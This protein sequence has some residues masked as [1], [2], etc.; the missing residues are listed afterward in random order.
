MSD[1]TTISHAVAVA[2]A[3][4]HTSQLWPTIGRAGSALAAIGGGIGSILAWYNRR[5]QKELRVLVNGNLGAALSGIERA[6]VELA[7]ATAERDI[8]R[9]DLAKVGTRTTD[10]TPAVTTPIITTS[11]KEH[12]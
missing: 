7:K 4:R 11:S 5:G 10:Q 8:A 12:A 3:H 2:L 1:P 9:A 6:A